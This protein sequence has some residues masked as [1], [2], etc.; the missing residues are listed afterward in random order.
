MF[1]VV[2][3][4]KKVF[5][6]NCN[7]AIQILP[8]SICLHSHNCCLVMF[9]DPSALRVLG[10]ALL[11][12]L[13]YAS[14]P[15]AATMS[16]GCENVW[17]G[18]SPD[19]ELLACLLNK[20][21]I[22]SR[23]KDY[24]FP[25][26]AALL[27]LFLLLIFP[28]VFCFQTCCPCGKP[29]QP[30]RSVRQERRA[31]CWMRAWAAVGLLWIAAAS[32]AGL[33]SL[34]LTRDGV[35]GVLQETNA[36]LDHFIIVKDNIITNIKNYSENPPTLPDNFNDSALENLSS[37]TA[38]FSQRS[39]SY[40]RFVY[41]KLLIGIYVG[42]GIGVG[43]F[44]AGMLLLL[45]CRRSF[46]SGLFQW[47]FW[48][49]GILFGAAAVILS[50]LEYGVRT[51]C[52]EAELQYE[53][54]PGIAQW[55]LIPY[56]EN[57][58]QFTNLKDTIEDEISQRSKDACG[59]LLDICDH[60]PNLALPFTA[61]TKYFECGPHLQTAA[62]CQNFGD[63]A[64]AIFTTSAKPSLKTVLCLPEETLNY[65]PKC[66]I[67][68]CA[69]YCVNYPYD[70]LNVKDQAGNATYLANYAHNASVA[71]FYLLPLLNIEFLVDSSF[72]P[73]IAKD[74]SS[75]LRGNS[76]CKN[77]GF[78]F[79]VAGIG[80]LLGM[81]AFVIGIYALMRE[82]CIR[83]KELKLYENEPNC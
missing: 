63:V 14:T 30:F 38:S 79:T 28:F 82:T 48:F 37:K 45:F 52:K 26:I 70:K 2:W 11:C 17:K 29:R 46:L 35:I 81:A 68:D 76:Y 40:F 67:P 16:L 50:L 59:A 60:D 77:V 69:E 51:V 27:L 65:T 64:D 44:L 78:T 10:V 43:V 42:S 47:M 12:V 19:N 74:E 39:M 18:P 75:A 36:T 62:S 15:A 53:R 61:D 24:V 6:Y 25:G 34:H 4:V 8:T 83:R 1:G 49:F 72:R 31:R 58:F 73:L 41:G 9:F 32:I 20:D 80:F 23:W 3:L 71:I 57:R 33:Y 7:K 5:Q 13:V 66:T 21:R 55:F 56:F 54:K 22:L